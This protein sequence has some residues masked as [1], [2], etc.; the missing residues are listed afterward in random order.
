MFVVVMLVDIELSPVLQIKLAI[1]EKNTV[2]QLRIDR[3]KKKILVFGASSRFFQ[4]GAKQMRKGGPLQDFFFG[5]TRSMNRLF[6][7]FYIF[8]VDHS[9]YETIWTMT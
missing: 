2:K 1:S 6:D 9:L 7:F 3:S 8:G 5:C 4:R